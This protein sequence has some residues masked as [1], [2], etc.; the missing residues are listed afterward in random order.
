MQLNAIFSSGMVFA[1]DHPIRIYG[2]GEGRAEIV[3]AGIKQQIVSQNGEW[4][5]E[6]H[7]MECGG[8]H[9]L[10]LTTEGKEIVL[11][12][13]YVGEV[14]L[15]AGQSNMQFKIK[16]GQDDPA[17]CETNEMLRLF[18]PRCIE[19]TDFYK[20]E[21]GWVKAEKSMAPMWSALAHYTGIQLAKKKNI[22]IGIIAC[23]QGASVIESWVP[24]GVLEQNGIF[25]EQKDKGP[26]HYTEPY[27]AWNH[28]GQLY[29]HMISQVKPFSLTGVVWYQGES[30][31]T[32]AEAKV[33]DKELAIL[34][35]TW[36][37]DFIDPELPFVIIQIANYDKRDDE[38]WHMIQQV[39]YDIQFTVPHVTT[40]ISADAC[41]SDDVHPPK[42]YA[43]AQKL[44][45][46]LLNNQGKA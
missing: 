22:A 8:P 42:K 38:G 36:R 31:T 37:K 2:T 46:A 10:V 5:V 12:D 6:F 7:P 32:V 40:V 25:V 18:S 28:N 1:K 14:Y 30:D 15:F 16:Q 20:P 3:F 19:D 35:D 24:K 43:L 29:D 44:A 39:Q 9:E 41:R 23:Y 27:C 34:I 11:N 21:D 33:Y 17:F 13:I 4:F 45:N 26:S